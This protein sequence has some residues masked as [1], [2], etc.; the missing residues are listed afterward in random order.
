M[1]TNLTLSCKRVFS[2]V[3]DGVV[4]KVFQGPHL[5]LTFFACPSHLLVAGA[6]PA[7]RMSENS[8]KQDLYLR[9]STIN[10][11]KLQSLNVLFIKA[12]KPKRIHCFEK[13]TVK[14]IHSMCKIPNPLPDRCLESVSRIQ[15]P[16][17][18]NCF[19]LQ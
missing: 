10:E 15:L 9:I 13:S 3:Q 17:T 14:T 12:S 8:R 6:A 5:S 11:I 1:N 16:L 19:S 7:N 2:D 4:I 18:T